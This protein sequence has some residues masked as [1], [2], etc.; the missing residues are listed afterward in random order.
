MLIDVSMIGD[1]ARMLTRT[2]T[3]ARLS[4]DTLKRSLFRMRGSDFPRCDETHARDQR[5]LT[6]NGKPGAAGQ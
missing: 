6:A 2:L 4:G 1:D 3:V 5:R